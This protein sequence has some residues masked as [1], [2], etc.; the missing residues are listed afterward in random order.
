[1]GTAHPGLLPMFAKP[2]DCNP[3]I[4]PPCNIHRC[5]ICIFVRW[6]DMPDGAFVKQTPIRIYF[7]RTSCK[8]LLC[9]EWR[10]FLS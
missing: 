10:L 6:R 8:V 9:S 5:S 7:R 1:M 3:F 2:L 4:M